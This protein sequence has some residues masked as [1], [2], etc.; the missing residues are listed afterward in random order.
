MHLR[1]TFHL[2]SPLVLTSEDSGTTY[3]SFPPGISDGDADDGASE[4]ATLSGGA[5]LEGLQW[6]EVPGEPHVWTASL[7]GSK[8]RTPPPSFNSLFVDGKRAIRARYPNGD[9]LQPGEGFTLTGKTLGCSKSGNGGMSLL[10]NNVDVVGGGPKQT[11]LLSTGYTSDGTNRTVSLPYPTVARPTRQNFVSYRGGTSDRFDHTWNGDYWGSDVPQGVSNVAGLEN[12]PSWRNASTAVVHMYHPQGWGGWQ[13]S[14]AERPDG[15]GTLLFACEAQAGRGNFSG[16]CTKQPTSTAVHVEGGWQEARGSCDVGAF[17][18]ENVRELVDS[19]REW[20]LDESEST[21]YYYHEGSLEDVSNLEFVAAVLANVFTVQ[22]G[23]SSNQAVT[24]VAL[25]NVRIAH[26]RTTF[27][28]RYEV[29]SGGDWSVHRGAA[30]FVGGPAADV[31][32]EGCFF[33]Q[34]GGN[35]VMLSN[36]VRDSLVADNTIIQAGDSAIVCLGSTQFFNGT[37]AA[38]Q[39]GPP[40]AAAA[41]AG[42]PPPRGL[43]GFPTANTIRHNL[44]DTVGVFGK[45][46][47]AY[48]KALSDSNVVLENVFLNGPRAAINFND[49]GPGGEQL[50]GNLFFNFVRESG[51]HGMFNSWDRQPYLYTTS[52]GGGADGE[53][54]AT[55]ALSPRRHQI[56]RNFCLNANYATTLSTRSGYCFDYDDGSSQYNATSNVM[57]SGGF[58]DRDGVNRSHANNL[59]VSGRLADPQVAGFDTETFDGNTV[60]DFTGSFYSCVGSAFPQGGAGGVRLTNNRYFTPAHADLP[61]H[62]GCGGGC[63]KSNQTL[64]CWQSEGFDAGSTILENATVDEVLAWARERLDM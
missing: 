31:S 16:A 25:S 59:V 42:T 40:A 15:G 52:T 4:T 12:M 7:T 14:V 21:L 48:F 46:T 49:G 56:H 32:I 53:E 34:V 36:G 39:H 43:F 63:D 45:Q 61:F 55:T 64:A 35:A 22:G 33:D 29:P 38:Q 30:V 1:G 17:Y 44:V 51:D 50:V 8:G 47:S 27:M 6:S 54:G 28:D 2:P 58:K 3:T 5:L 37:R 24:N 23:A 13:F 18:V 10:A 26:T 62:P 9:P 57:V 41:A 20:Y 60:I 11:V 19:A